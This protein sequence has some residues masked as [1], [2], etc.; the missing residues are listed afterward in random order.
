MNGEIRS[1]NAN[2]APLRCDRTCSLS[3][4]GQRID[5]TIG[6]PHARAL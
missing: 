3:L 4:I 2:G 6:W 1:R 5:V